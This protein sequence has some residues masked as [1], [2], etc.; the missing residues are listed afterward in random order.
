MYTKKKF[1][2]TWV[3]RDLDKNCKMTPLT[4]AHV[5]FVKPNTSKPRKVW[6]VINII[7]SF[8]IFKESALDRFF[9]RVA[10]SVYLFMYLCMYL[11]HFHVIFLRGIRQ[12]LAW[13][14]TGSCVE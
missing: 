7:F 10:M 2:L 1:K 13:N 8:G 6:G 11:S 4:T 14:K 12:A 5:G 9:H 3:K